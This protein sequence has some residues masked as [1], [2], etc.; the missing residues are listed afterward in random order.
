[1]II[2]IDFLINIYVNGNIHNQPNW[3][4]IES[5]NLLLQMVIDSK[6][7]FSQL[8]FTIVFMNILI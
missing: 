3:F 1:M 2:T 4:T 8:V 6:I 7:N 5:F